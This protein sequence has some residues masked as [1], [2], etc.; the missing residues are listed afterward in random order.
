[1]PLLAQFVT[2]MAS[3]APFGSGQVINELTMPATTAALQLARERVDADD[4]GGALAALDGLSGPAATAMRPWTDGA[5]ARLATTAA[6]EVLVRSALAE[7]PGAVSIGAVGGGDPIAGFDF[8]NSPSSLQRA[9]LTGRP[10]VMTTAAGVRGRILDV[11]TGIVPSLGFEPRIEFEGAVE[12]V[13]E[14]FDV[15]IVTSRQP[16]YDALDAFVASGDCFDC[17]G[18]LRLL[19]SQDLRDMLC[20]N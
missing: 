20:S 16:L 2:W 6:M 19:H 11:V 14:A 12:T 1:M 10:V 5:R 15:S 4:L 8:G 17:S 13:D 3:T 9:D 18:G 7:L